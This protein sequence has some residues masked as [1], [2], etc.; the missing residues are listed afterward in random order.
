MAGPEDPAARRPKRVNSEQKH[1]D[2]LE[3]HLHSNPNVFLTLVLLILIGLRPARLAAQLR[4]NDDEAWLQFRSNLHSHQKKKSNS[5]YPKRIARRPLILLAILALPTLFAIGAMLCFYAAVTA[6]AFQNL[7]SKAV[8]I[9]A[10]IGTTGGAALIA[11][12]I[13]AAGW[14][15][16]DMEKDDDEETEVPMREMGS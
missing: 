12:V 1:L 5:M 16:W 4:A 2:R 13:F 15:V 6:L 7:D 3:F 14:L 8:D 11:G 10:R 9:L